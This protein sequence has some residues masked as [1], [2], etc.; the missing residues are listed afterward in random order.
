LNALP[1]GL[2]TAFL[3]IKVNG[4]GLFE[5]LLEVICQFF[6]PADKFD[7]VVV[8]PKT[9]KPSPAIPIIRPL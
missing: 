8:I 9:E 6:T 5:G 4:N 3:A 2:Q 1:E 7:I